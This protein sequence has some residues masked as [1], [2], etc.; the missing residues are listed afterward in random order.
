MSPSVASADVDFLAAHAAAHPDKRAVIVA[1]DDGDRV[2]TYREFNAVVNT[3]ANAMTASGVRSGDRVAWCGRNGVEVLAVQQAA[4]KL[5]LTSVPLNFHLRRDELTWILGNAEVVMV[6][7]AAE[8]SPL[9]EDLAVE[10]PSVRAVVV[11]DGPAGPGEIT[12]AEVSA[13]VDDTEPQID[14]SGAAAS[15]IIYTSGTTGK[16]KGAVRD[17]LTTP[18]QRAV[19]RSHLDM[20]GVGQDD[21][22]LPTGALH[23]GGPLSFADLTLANGDTV[24][25]QSKFDPEG[26]LALLTRY[27]ANTSYSAPTAIRRI[28]SLPDE[29]K[30]KYDTSSMRLML[31]GAAA[32]PYALKLAYLDDFPEHS[33]WE[34]YGSTELGTNTILRPEDQRRKP[35]SCGRA[36]P[37]VEIVLL[38]EDGNEITQPHVPGELFVR[39]GS[40]FR[41]YYKDEEKFLAEHR[42]DLH[43]V[44]DI[45]YFDEE[46][47]YYIC[48]RKKDMV[49]TGGVNVYPAEVEAALEGHPGIF[50][51]AVYGLPDD[52]WG[53]RVH[54]T[55][56]LAPGASLDEQDVIAY[57]RSQLASYKAPKSVD[58]VDEL[59]HSG[60]G[61]ILKREL[62]ARRLAGGDAR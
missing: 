31:A 10:V 25:L 49:I 37:G 13:G 53:E 43:T 8:Q 42:G 19:L 39:G 44:G 38:D 57:C 36:A 18:E 11:F 12:L 3:F 29:V 33:L 27:R 34:L 52:E 16:P 14:R 1:G 7:T 21:V 30:A 51:S 59:P 56:V 4:R 58:F 23:H 62:R 2:V 17:A 20:L 6:W 9:F 54:A 5:A 35:G 32:W 61:K 41:T 45:A 26:W 46:G 24:V 60:S 40:R 28:C 22:Y 15:T 47:Y 48:D 55:V 50:E